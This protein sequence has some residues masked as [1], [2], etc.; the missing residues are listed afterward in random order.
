MK[1]FFA[2]TYGIAA[3]CWPFALYYAPRDQWNR[4]LGPLAQ[5][6]FVAIHDA[7]LFIH[8]LDLRALQSAR[9]VAAAAAAGGSEAGAD[10][11]KMRGG[12]E[13]VLF[14]FKY[15]TAARA[16]RGAG[17]ARPSAGGG[18]VVVEIIR[19][20]AAACA[21]VGALWFVV[22]ATWMSAFDLPGSHTPL[23]WK[24]DL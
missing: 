15:T 7:G 24:M 16:P 14:L 12:V 20:V 22:S 9:R 21:V 23:P 19:V 4:T 3:L 2:C 18:S 17:G 11:T 6:F 10:P 1:L 5:L 8:V 13:P